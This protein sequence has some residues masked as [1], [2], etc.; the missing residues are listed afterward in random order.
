MPPWVGDL[1]LDGAM[2]DGIAEPCSVS[3]IVFGRVVWWFE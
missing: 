2:A 3:G 1:L